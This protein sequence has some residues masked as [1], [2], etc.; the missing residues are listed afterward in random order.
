MLV[1]S[2][3]NI[4]LHQTFQNETIQ[5]SLLFECVLFGHQLVPLHVSGK[6]LS[7]MEFQNSFED[8]QRK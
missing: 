3:Q 2:L 7:W 5:F 8:Y 1:K 6:R 4:A